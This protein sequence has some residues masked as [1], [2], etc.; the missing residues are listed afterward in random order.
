MKRIFHSILASLLLLT[1]SSQAQVVFD[2]ASAT[3]TAA[4]I[5]YQKTGVGTYF[6]STTGGAVTDGTA[7]CDS[8]TPSKAT[9]SS[10][11]YFVYNIL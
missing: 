8:Y 2:F 1:A 5:G 4:P 3:A 11:F 10:I 6:R 7:N 9:S